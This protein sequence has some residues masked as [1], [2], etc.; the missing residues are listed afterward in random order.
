[1]TPTAY[2]KCWGVTGSALASAGATYF[3]QNASRLK[4]LSSPASRGTSPKLIRSVHHTESTS[5]RSAVSLFSTVPVISAPEFLSS[6]QSEMTG[7]G[8]SAVDAVRCDAR[9]QSVA[10]SMTASQWD[11]A[12]RL[13]P[14]VTPDESDGDRSLSSRS[15]IAGAMNPENARARAGDLGG[16]GDPLLNMA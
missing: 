16:D 2:M 10:R 14:G 4:N 8:D 6:T 5:L 3:G 12:E 13:S 15:V 9:A 7:F 11:S 1:M